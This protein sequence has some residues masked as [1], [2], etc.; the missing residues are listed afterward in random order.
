MAKKF[1]K[2]NAKRGLSTIV[3]TLIIILV[4]IVAIGIVWAFVNNMIKSQIHSSESCYGNYDKIKINRMYTCF[5]RIS[6]TNYNLRFS[7]SMGDVSVDKV[8]VSV[9]S[10]GNVNSYEITN[11]PKNIINLVMYS[12]TNPSNV[13]LPAKNAGLTY[14]ATG[15][16]AK[17]DSIEISPYIQGTLCGVSDSVSE[18]EDCKLIF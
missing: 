4:S 10:A 12:G 18:I 16:S 15:F 1:Y 11:T 7:L 14:N 2:K 17:I 9:S 5:E 6:A 3:I 8:I 13:I